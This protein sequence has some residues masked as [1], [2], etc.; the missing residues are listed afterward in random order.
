MGLDKLL[1]LTLEV[2]MNLRM[3]GS[4]LATL[5]LA[6]VATGSLWAQGASSLRGVVT[7]P[8]K[9]VLPDAKVTLTD[10]ENGAVRA[11]LTSGSGTYQF[12]QLRPGN[13][14]LTAE[15]PGFATKKVDNI[16]LLVDSPAT[17]DLSLEIAS[18]TSTIS[19]IAET[20]QL[21]TVDASVGNAFAERQVQSLP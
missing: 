21:N 11:T 14:S 20:A 19:V 9:A 13:Y 10:V 12:L 3:N 2:S 8:Q 15:V 1:I 16:K 6:C 18:S 4:I 5:Y 7:D 17:L